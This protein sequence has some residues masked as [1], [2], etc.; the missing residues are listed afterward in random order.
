MNVQLHTPPLPHPDKPQ[1]TGA[2]CRAM[3][4]ASSPRQNF[5]F[6]PALDSAVYI[7]QSQYLE[8]GTRTRPC[9]IPLLSGTMHPINEGPNTQLLQ[10]L[11]GNS[12]TSPFVLQDP[13]WRDSSLWCFKAHIW[14]QTAQVQGQSIFGQVIQPL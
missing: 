5:S 10:S 3:V 7:H 12:G 9:R 1:Q 6:W 11:P 13:H 8:D 14:G 2:T 4:F